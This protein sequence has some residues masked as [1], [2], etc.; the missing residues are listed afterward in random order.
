MSGD[1]WAS[2][3]P[4]H[5]T[6][7]P[8][9]TARTIAAAVARD[10]QLGRA[11]EGDLLRAERMAYEEERRARQRPNPGL[12]PDPAWD[13]GCSCGWRGM[14]EDVEAHAEVCELP[15]PWQVADDAENA[16]TVQVHVDRDGTVRAVCSCGDLEETGTTRRVLQHLGAHVGL[17]ASAARA[18]V[19][20]SVVRERRA[21]MN[22]GP[23]RN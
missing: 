2:V 15:D 12:A 16:P 10:V 14:G 11:T 1:E 7:H 9:V 3:G 5:G 19:P 21:R 17:H 18:L 4:I 23:G 13:A 6:E 8:A 20:W 22:L